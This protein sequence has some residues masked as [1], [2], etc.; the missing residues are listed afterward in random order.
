VNVDKWYSA[1]NAGSTA[2]A[3]NQS[4]IAATWQSAMIVIEN[5]FEG[6][7][8]TG[9]IDCPPLPA[10][11]ARH[12][13][14]GPNPLPFAPFPQSIMALNLFSRLMPP[15]KSFT[16]QF[17]EQTKCIHEAAQELRDMV[18]G[19]KTSADQHVASIR[20][21]EAQADTVA[22]QI[23]MSAN[24]T[25][26]APIDREDILLLAHD[27]DDVVDLIED[28]AKGIQRYAISE[29]AEEMRKMVDAVVQSADLLKE[30][31]PHLD[32]IT[33]DHKAIFAL[34]ERIGNIEQS[35]DESF[36]AGLSRIRKELGTGQLNPIG[37]LDRK[38]LYEL[39]ERVVD[40]CDDVANVVQ[41]VTAKHV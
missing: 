5:D 3:E 4:D 36:D 13:R 20:K 17:C 39:I 26:Q 1:I 21:I 27:L 16:S 24:R 9:T 11:F 29:F 28:T 22:R 2:D 23:F 19:Q 7:R 25:F 35:A 37:Y 12:R 18:D 41:T 38:E 33:R 14:R 32:S 10:A 8:W 30:I 6:S 34:C 31:M 15:E 40:K